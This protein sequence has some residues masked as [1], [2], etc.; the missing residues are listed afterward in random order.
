MFRAENKL[1][2]ALYQPKN[3]M[4]SCQRPG[5]LDPEEPRL[6]TMKLTITM[7]SWQTC[8]IDKAL[9]IYRKALVNAAI[10][11]DAT[12]FGK[13]LQEL[14]FMPHVSSSWRGISQ[15]VKTNNVQLR[16]E[17]PKK[18][19]EY[20]RLAKEREEAISNHNDWNVIILTRICMALTTKRTYSRFQ[21]YLSRCLKHARNFFSYCPI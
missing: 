12:G 16:L 17:R 14:S 6:P 15:V 21:T 13:T 19:V 11:A 2:N 7:K 1:D 4:D 20:N 18:V 9:E 8:G 5:D 3:F 10:F